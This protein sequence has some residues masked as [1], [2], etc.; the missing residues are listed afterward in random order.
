MRVSFMAK[1]RTPIPD[2]LVTEVLYASDHTYCICREREKEPQIHHIDKNP[3]NNT[4]ENLA[5][6]CPECH[7]KTQI[8]GGFTR[9]LT[10]SLVT[11]YRDE[12]L[13]T[14]DL[15]RNLANEMAV[16]REVGEVGISQRIKTNPQIKVQP[17]QHLMDPF[18]YIKSLP[19][20]KSDLLQQVKE[21]K[22]N[23]STLDIVQANSDYIDALTGILVILANFYS[24][25]CFG[26]QS[27][28]EFFSEILSS[29]Y[30]FYSMLSAPDGP[31]TGGTIRSI[32]FGHYL[33]SDIE[34]M[35]IDMVSGLWVERYS[36]YEDWERQWRSKEI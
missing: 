9:K 29:R 33:I 6:L 5:A 24:P 21:Q 28:Q 32:L 4:F 23:G 36:E 2:S 11:K 17:S 7:H 35:I 19:K 27:P 26:E 25:E 30:Q 20:Y 16:K 13:K 18:P 12:W 22:F 14:V 34:N 15:R 31:G 8:K 10:P 1:H 3:S